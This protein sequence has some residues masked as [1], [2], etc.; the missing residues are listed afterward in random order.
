MKKNWQ[1][2]GVILLLI[3][4][5]ACFGGCSKKGP[6]E[7]AGEK[8]DEGIEGAKDN[9]EDAVDGQGPM[10]KAGEATDSVIDEGKD[11]LGGD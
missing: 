11:A 3:V 9:V 10:E 5:L 1:L 6:A 8:I 2:S 4:T 7:K